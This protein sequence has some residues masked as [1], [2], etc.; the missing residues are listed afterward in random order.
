MSRVFVCFITLSLLAFVPFNVASGDEPK[1]K[2]DPKSEP[3]LS[4]QEKEI[5][6]LTNKERDKEKLLPLEP[7]A[8][9][10]KAARAHSAN[11]AKTGELSHV[12]DGKDPGKRL[13]A[14][15]YDWLEVGENIAQGTDETLADIMKL[16]M[17]SELHRANI[18]NKDFKQIGIGIVKNDKGEVYY[19]QVF[20]T[21][22]K[23]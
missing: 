15:G 10:F 11:M 5:L 22:R 21:P 20:G 1:P 13:D 17:G 4:K 16:W 8:L 3:D 7:N 12:L 18:L 9:L 14:V 19:T 6:E 2:P 23:K